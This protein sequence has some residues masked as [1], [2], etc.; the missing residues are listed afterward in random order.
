MER[1]LLTGST[2]YIGRRLLPR[3]IR[4]GYHIT[5]L[6]RD[7]ARF[8][9]E[10]FTTESLNRIVVIEGDLLDPSSLPRIEE[11]FQYAFFLAHSMVSSSSNFDQLESR[12]AKNFAAFA[13]DN[14]CQHIV[15]LGG[16]SNDSNLSKHLLSRMEVETALAETRIPVTVLRAAIIIGSGSASFEI[17][18]DLVE[19]L[20]VMV[21]PKWLNTRCQ[22]IAIRNVLE[23]LVGVL[24]KP[25]SLGKTYDIGGPEVLTYKEMLLGYARVRKLKRYI[26]T[27]PVLTPRLSSL[28]LYF[29]TS[30]S[31]KLARSLVDSMRNEVVCN[32]K[33]T[34]RLDGQKLLNYRE[35]LEAALSKV[36]SDEVESSWTDSV[37]SQKMNKALQVRE[38]VPEHGCFQDYREIEFDSNPE[39]VLNNIW[40][41][42]GKRGWYYGNWLWEIRGFLDKMVGGVGLR[43]GRRN[44]N[45]IKAGDSIDFWRVLQANKVSRR[46]LLFAEMK[47]PGEAWLEFELDKKPTG[48]NILKQKATFRPRGLAGRLYW[49]SVLPFHAFIFQGMA[50]SITK[51]NAETNA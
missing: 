35:A 11:G 36:Q 3:L 38:K 8:D 24:T 14:N 21:A 51:S 43:R 29:V 19:K 37:S 17:I 49:Y 26:L 28:W 22:P 45:E 42:G 18:R 23:Q 48:K 10:D 13:K 20:P 25:Q 34:L 41:I 39:K 16:I 32:E 4:E 12:M 50:E 6:V 2:G 5:C 46:L 33:N 40:S 1:I 7:R 31:Y 27:L 47:L 15:Y 9:F 44:Q 30:T